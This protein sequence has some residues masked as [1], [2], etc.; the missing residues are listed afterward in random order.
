MNV[1]RMKMNTRNRLKLINSFIQDNTSAVSTVS[2]IGDMNVEIS[3][4]NSLYANHKA[5]F[6]QD[7]N[8]IL[9]SKVLL[10]SD[11]YTYI[12]EALHNTSWL[13]HGA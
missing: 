4:K 11:S 13:D 7:N 3:D 2:V 6:C 12:S 1:I 8:F 10:L 5:Q 9:T